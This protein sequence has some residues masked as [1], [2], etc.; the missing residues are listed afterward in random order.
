MTEESTTKFPPTVG[1]WYQ[2]LPGW[3]KSLFNV[4]SALV[5]DVRAINWCGYHRMIA[6]IDAQAD[7]KFFD[8]IGELLVEPEFNRSVLNGYTG[9]YSL[10]LAGKVNRPVLHLSVP[11]ASV[12]FPSHVI[13]DDRQI[14]IVVI[15]NWSPP[16][17][18]NKDQ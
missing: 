4:L 14:P 9:L 13:I 1:E 8:R 10:G 5:G 6:A 3:K 12:R 15:T 7:A 16:R 11:K 2:G 17:P 18:L